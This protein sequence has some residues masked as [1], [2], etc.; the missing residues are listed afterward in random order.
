[1]RAGIIG[2]GVAGLSAAIALRDLGH[3]VVVL[4]SRPRDQVSR[5]AGHVHRLDGTGWAALERLIGPVIRAGACEMAASGLAS[6]GAVAWGNEQRLATLAEL[7][8]VLTSQAERRG[9]ELVSAAGVTTVAAERNRWRLGM[10]SGPG[11]TFDLLIDA[12]GSRRVLLDLLGEAG[13]SVWMDELGGPEWHVSFAGTGP[14]RSPALVAWAADDLE[15]LIQIDGAGRATVTA[16][17]G[18]S[19]ALSS[20]RIVTAMRVAGGAGMV[21][22]LDGLDLG[23]D[24]LRYVSVGTRMMALDEADL[25]SWPPFALVGDALIEAPPRHGEGMARAID[26]ALMLAERLA[27]GSPETCAADLTREARARW[28]GYGIAQALRSAAA[29]SP[30]RPGLSERCGQAALVMDAAGS[31]RA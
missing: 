19:Q 11:G 12:S 13:P 31:D 30:L 7:E 23:P 17:W 15:G 5:R 18:T 28:A 21:A 9:A 10:A 29:A 20:D 25:G 8:A 4:D 27:C 22:L 6:G 1:V 16:R 14:A 3:E 2:A 26:Q 24:A